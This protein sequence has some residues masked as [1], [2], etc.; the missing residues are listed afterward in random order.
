RFTA[1]A[2]SPDLG[3]PLATLARS[4]QAGGSLGAQFAE[5]QQADSATA[6]ALVSL[7]E[8]LLEYLYTLP[9]HVAHLDRALGQRTEAALA[10]KNAEG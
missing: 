5:T 2:G 9:A 3:Q 6:A 4:L 1:L 10:V 8:Y 7:L